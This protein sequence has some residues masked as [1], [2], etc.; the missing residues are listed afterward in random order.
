MN[1]PLYNQPDVWGEQNGKNGQYGLSKEQIEENF[2]KIHTYEAWIMQQE[3]SDENA[4]AEN[5]E[6]TKREDEEAPLTSKP[7]N[8]NASEESSNKRKNDQAI[9]LADVKKLKAVEEQSEINEN[10]TQSSVN[11][12]NPTPADAN[13]PKFDPSRIEIDDDCFECKQKYRDPTRSDLIMYLHALSYKVFYSF[14]SFL[15]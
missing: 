5:V 1:D 13:L 12:D 15:F 14:F 7:A 4:E 2:L 10:A 6:D 11:C 3:R 9:D 8:E